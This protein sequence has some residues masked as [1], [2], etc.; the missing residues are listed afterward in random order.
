VLRD[1]SAIRRTLG[2]LPQSF[3]FHPTALLTDLFETVTLW[4]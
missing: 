1:H 2:Y 4:M 3:G